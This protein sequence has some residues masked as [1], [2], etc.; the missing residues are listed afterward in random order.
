MLSSGPAAC[1]TMNCRTF[2]RRSNMPV[3]A[4]ASSFACTAKMWE[5]FISSTSSSPRIVMRPESPGARYQT[6][7][8]HL[9][10]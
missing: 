6:H 3:T 10:S 1:D 4:P 5:R 9:L 8:P 7:G 2:D